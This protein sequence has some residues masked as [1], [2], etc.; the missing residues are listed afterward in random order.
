MTLSSTI[1][2]TQRISFRRL[3]ALR[4]TIGVTSAVLWFT[5]F[6][7]DRNATQQTWALLAG[8]VTVQSFGILSSALLFM[9]PKAPLIER[10]TNWYAVVASTMIWV[11]GL[12][13]AA[14]TG[15]SI[16]QGVLI[17]IAVGTG[18]FWLALVYDGFRPTRPVV[19]ERE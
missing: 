10:V 5:A 12:G 14:W 6:W 8:L 3:D 17:F 9:H 16:F 18:V 19:R 1:A 11:V 2:W 13:A 7:G 15:L 4:W